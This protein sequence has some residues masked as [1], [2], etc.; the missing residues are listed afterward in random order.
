[1]Y[2]VTANGRER[3]RVLVAQSCLTLHNPMDCSSLGSSVHG[4]LPGKDT[5]VGCHSLLQGIFPTQGSNLSL[6]YCR[7]MLYHLSHQG[8]PNDSSFGRDQNV[9]ESASVDDCLILWMYYNTP[10]WMNYIHLYGWT[11]CMWSDYNKAVLKTKNQLIISQNPWVR[12]QG[13]AW[14]SFLLRA[15]LAAIREHSGCLFL[16]SLESPAELLWLLA[17]FSCSWLSF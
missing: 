9:L 17:H 12:N 1:M 8:S 13:M 14:L 5:G 4:I 7:Q 3:G 10:L 11:V 2:G 6:L 15:H 16:W